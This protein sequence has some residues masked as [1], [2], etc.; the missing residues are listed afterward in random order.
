MTDVT[1]D[2]PQVATP[3]PPPPEPKIEEIV[4]P[5]ILDAI[6]K[7]NNRPDLEFVDFDAKAATKAGDNY[8][9]L[10]YSV[11]INFK[12]KTGEKEV[13]PVILK[14][15]PRNEIRIKMITDANIFV[16]DVNMYDKVLP[17]LERF[18]R[19]VV[20]LSKDEIYTP[21]PKCF[22]CKTDGKND[23]I[24]MEDL[25]VQGFRMA[26]RKVGLDFD[27]CEVV[28][29]AMARFHALSYGLYQGDFDKIVQDYPYLEE[30]A[31]SEEKQP[32][33]FK[34]MFKNAFD[35][36]AEMLRGT[37]EE[38]GADLVSKI[39]DDSYMGRMHQ[40]VGA[41]VRWAVINHGDCW[42][43]MNHYSSTCFN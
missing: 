15:L 14:V 39:F 10:I 33:I 25:K 9:S 42:L 19:E 41:K 35:Q 11:T 16:R 3:P 7:N 26:N 23:Y 21:W 30:F 27:H 17:A 18:Q 43:V 37:G 20:G 12:T 28:M 24:A 22:A 34:E 38:R 36:M 31:F 13:L 40:L 4:T 29:K 8:M 2:T 32:E 1:T 5:D 6:I